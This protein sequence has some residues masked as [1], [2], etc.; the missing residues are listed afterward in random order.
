MS[1]GPIAIDLFSVV[2]IVAVSL[3]IMYMVEV[4]IEVRQVTKCDKVSTSHCD[5]NC[6]RARATFLGR[7]LIT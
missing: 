2:L 4:L 5:L 6:T 3:V 7:T 1:G